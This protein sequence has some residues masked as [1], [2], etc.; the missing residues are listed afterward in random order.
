MF[1]M[2]NTIKSKTLKKCFYHVFFF[3]KSQF[4]GKTTE[5]VCKL[6]VDTIWPTWR[7]LFTGWIQVLL[8]S[9]NLNDYTIQLFKS[10]IG[11]LLT[12]KLFKVTKFTAYVY[13]FFN[14]V[15]IVIVLVLVPHWYIFQF[16]F[17]FYSDEGEVLY[18]F[19][20]QCK[21][22]TYLLQHTM[23]DQCHTNTFLRYT[24]H[25]IIIVSHVNLGALNM[26]SKVQWRH[27]PSSLTCGGWS[28]R[29]S[30]RFV[31][32]WKDKWQTVKLY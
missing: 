18:Y 4:E 31:S 14:V 25:Q 3:S 2:V 17:F 24:V 10:M 15:C 16:H 30:A 12:T 23:H 22:N 28:S 11:H 19:T 21:F 9:L 7:M 26:L 8:C 13:I 1:K 29:H 27:T 32:F 6:I 5:V 20:T